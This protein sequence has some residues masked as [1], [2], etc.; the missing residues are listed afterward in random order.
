MSSGRRFRGVARSSAYA[1]SNQAGSV[2]GKASA[3]QVSAALRPG[4][5]VWYQTV[6]PSLSDM[7]CAATLHPDGSGGDADRLSERGRTHARERVARL[8]QA[9]AE[10]A[11]LASPALQEVINDLQALRGIAGI[12]A[13][14]SAAELG[15]VSRF[16]S[17]RRLMGY[18]GA[19]P[20]EDS[21]GKRIRR[22]SR[23]HCSCVK[24][25]AS[26]GP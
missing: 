16:D 9:I 3:G 4:S 26:S 18:C 7:G 14:T 24:C 10:T 17:A 1:R 12:S 21:S 23:S 2:E 25:W 20:S 11:K 15:Q 8:E 22:G 5:T 19:G 13:V 6:D